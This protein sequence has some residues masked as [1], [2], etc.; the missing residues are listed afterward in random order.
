MVSRGNLPNIPTGEDRAYQASVREATSSSMRGKVEE[1]HGMPMKPSS[2]LLCQNCI[3]KVYF[4][5]E[6]LSIGTK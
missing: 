3:F 5:K 2:L 6:Y 4:S 1:K